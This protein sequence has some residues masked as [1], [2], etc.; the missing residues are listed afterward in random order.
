MFEKK[1]SFTDLPHPAQ[2][3]DEDIFETIIRTYRIGILILVTALVGA[4]F[5]DVRGLRITLEICWMQ[6]RLGPSLCCLLPPLKL[7]A[8]QKVNGEL[9]LFQDSLL[10]TRAFTRVQVS[11]SPFYVQSW[12]LLSSASKHNI[13]NLLSESPGGQWWAIQPFVMRGKFAQIRET[14][15]I[16][17]RENNELSS[18]RLKENIFKLIY[19]YF[20]LSIFWD[21]VLLGQSYP[22]LSDLE[23]ATLNRLVST[24]QRYACLLLLKCYYRYKRPHWLKADLW[25]DSREPAWCV[26][27]GRWKQIELHQCKITI[28]WGTE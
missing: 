8:N 18:E 20:Y 15:N 21:K 19:V 16:M 25:W 23:L 5:S 10:E 9:C 2:H 12:V 11:Y 17:G 4:A 6:E 3:S 26:C 13:P 14:S 7:S 28:W 24:L 1:V 27:L 22:A